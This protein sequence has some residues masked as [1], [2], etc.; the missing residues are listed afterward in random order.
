MI[1][2]LK[3]FENEWKIVVKL[4]QIVCLEDQ[5]AYEEHN[6]RDNLPGGDEGRAD[7]VTVPHSL[8][9]LLLGI[10]S[11]SQVSSLVGQNHLQ[12]FS[13]PHCH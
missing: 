12:P 3:T 1:S 10:P 7:L 2:I 9:L 6:L 8:A 4:G 5:V 11:S 13:T